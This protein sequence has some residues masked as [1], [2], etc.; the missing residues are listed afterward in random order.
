MEWTPSAD[1]E[2]IG[3]AA[4]ASKD[5]PVKFSMSDGPCQA[6]PLKAVSSCL[7]MRRASDVVDCIWVYHNVDMRA[8][9]LIALSIAVILPAAA[10][11]TKKPAPGTPPAATPAPAVQKNDDAYTAKI[12]QYTTETFFSTEL[13]DHL[14]ASDTVPSPDKVLGYVI[15][16][17]NKL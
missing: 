17:P 7:L 9:A 8:F 1:L 14:P 4:A 6:G 16:T 12:R 10:Q 15:G 11:K 3:F 2:R 13:I 5:T